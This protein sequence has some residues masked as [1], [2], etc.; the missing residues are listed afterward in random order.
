M[1]NEHDMVFH[2]LQPLADTLVMPKRLK[3]VSQALCETGQEP[4]N[5]IPRFPSEYVDR[6]M[7]DAHSG[8]IKTCENLFCPTYRNQYVILRTH[9]PGLET[10]GLKR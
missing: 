8:E 6:A 7:V 10:L 2:R 1:Q 9:I 5:L 4:R 3:L